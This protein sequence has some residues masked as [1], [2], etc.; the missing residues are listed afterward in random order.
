VFGLVGVGA[1]LIAVG[2]LPTLRQFVVAALIVASCL[3]PWFLWQQIVEPPGNALIK[4]ALA[5]T[6]DRN[7][8]LFATV[9]QA[10]AGLSVAEWL[11]MKAQA[12]QTLF[13]L[14]SDRCG[15]TEMGGYYRG[16]A[17]FG[18]LRIADFLYLFP[19]LGFLNLGWVSFFFSCRRGQWRFAASEP[20]KGFAAANI[21]IA[22]FSLVITCLVTWS[23]QIT[24]TLPF[25]SIVQ[26]ALGLAIFLGEGPKEIRIFSAL[27]LFVYS[28]AVWILEPIVDSLHVN[29]FAAFLFASLYLAI[30]AIFMRDVTLG[31]RTMGESSRFL[32]QTAPVHGTQSV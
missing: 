27:A 12:F 8:G 26:L 18:S 14:S 9:K 32:R 3:L 2:M 25:L 5:G 22:T 1:W 24:V 19:S 30:C 31:P 13:G 4:F 20:A 16:P 21:L 11:R 17:I 15:L 7:V 29:V 28:L 10:Y 23:C 6:A